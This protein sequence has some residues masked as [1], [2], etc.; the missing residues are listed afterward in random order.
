MYLEQSWVVL[1]LLQPPPC[2]FAFLVQFPFLSPGVLT[3]AHMIIGVHMRVRA[4]VSFFLQ[5]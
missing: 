5:S 4:P 1:P 2:V 3:A